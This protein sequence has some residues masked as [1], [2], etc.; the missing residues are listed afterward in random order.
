[1]R[2]YNA[3]YYR[4]DSTHFNLIFL[5]GLHTFVNASVCHGV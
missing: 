4:S 3:L 2:V 5:D 1:M